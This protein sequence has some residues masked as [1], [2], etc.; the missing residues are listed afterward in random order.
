MTR[1]ARTSCA[2]RDKESVSLKRFSPTIVLQQT[3][4]HGLLL[5]LALQPF[6]SF[7]VLM[8]LIAAEVVLISTLTALLYP[9]RGLRRHA[10]DLVK[11]L[12]SHA[13]ILSLVTALYLAASGAGNHLSSFSDARELL[14][15]QMQQAHLGWLLGYA[16]THLLLILL[17]ALGSRDRRLYWAREAIAEGAASLLALFTLLVLLGAFLILSDGGLAGEHA[18]DTPPWASITLVALRFAFALLLQHMPG[19]EWART[20]RSPYAP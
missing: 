16:V 19:D 4:L 1:Q 8:L 2:A 17:F 7:F 9:E 6:M 5:W 10:I 18:A 11:V 15:A 13:I 14:T 3:L 12:L 20:A